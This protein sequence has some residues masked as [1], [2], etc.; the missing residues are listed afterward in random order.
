MVCDGDVCER[1]PVG[2][3]LAQTVAAS[4]A[5]PSSDDAPVV[6]DAADSMSGARAGAVAAD[7]TAPDGNAAPPADENDTESA[8]GATAT[9]GE[10]EKAGGG[11]TDGG[12]DPSDE[13]DDPAV[14]QLVEMGWEKPEA[15]AALK[16]AGG[17][18]LTAAEALAEAEE[19]REEEF[20]R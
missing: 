11:P 4:I 17:D 20:E 1:K 16:E 5:G 15:V 18:M 6:D 8:V 19:K 12:D 13:E 14:D 10:A 3:K 9:S 2:P 7:S